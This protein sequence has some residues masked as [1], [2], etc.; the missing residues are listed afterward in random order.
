MTRAE[1]EALIQELVVRSNGDLCVRYERTL[2]RKP[3][4]KA[5]QPIVTISR[6]ASRIAASAFAT[7]LGVTTALAQSPASPPEPAACSSPVEAP[8]A[9][10]LP[11]EDPE[12]SYASVGGNTGIPRAGLTLVDSRT[13]AEQST[14]ADDDGNYSFDYVLPGTYSLRLVDGDSNE[15][16]SVTDI[17]V[18]SGDQVVQA[19]GGGMGGIGG[20]IAITSAAESMLMH[21]DE[22]NKREADGETLPPIFEAVDSGEKRTV[23]RA[24]RRGAAVDARAPFGDTAL[25][26]AVDDIDILKVLIDAGADV[27]ARNEFG[28]TPIMYAAVRYDSQEAIPLLVRAGAD[29][30]AADRDGRTALMFAAV[31]GRED[32][33]RALLDAGADPT[34]RDSENMS[35][36]AFAAQSEDEEVIRMIEAAGAL[37]ERE[38]KAAETAQEVSVPEDV[39]EDEEVADPAVESDAGEGHSE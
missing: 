5:P 13:G 30:N 15:P 37:P 2:D 29:V 12:P 19:L 27:N 8:D 14:I 33:V 4:F 9:A 32:L 38:L 25:M 31:D 39:D 1:A 24:L 22:R 7:A 10:L 34:A 28:V 17:S 36:W 3:L 21:Y 11:I 20:A 16:L 35:V 6:R 26:S 23:K 18:E